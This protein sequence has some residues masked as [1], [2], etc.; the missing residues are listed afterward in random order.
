MLLNRF[1]P[2]IEFDNY[3]DFKENYKVNVPENFNFGYDIVDEW[4]K[5][6]PEKLALVWCNDHNEEYKFTFTDISKLSNKA[7]NYFKS[8]GIS[9]GSVVMLILRRRWEYWIC[10]VALHKI[11]AIVIPGS[12]QLTAKDI[13]YR[14]NAAE[15][16]AIVSINDD[17]VIN[18]IESADC[19][20]PSLKLK[21]VV[22][23]K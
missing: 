4:A 8:I 11:G 1:L 5:Q 23:E 16:T 18:Q 14:G 20:I 7:A 2:R 21:I 19:D 10:A 3:E 22:G 12:L 9:K 15:I 13:V 17:F 6:E